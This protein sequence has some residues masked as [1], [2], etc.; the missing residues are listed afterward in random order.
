MREEAGGGEGEESQWSGIRVEY[1]VRA[2]A[3]SM[4]LKWQTLTI[5]GDMLHRRE[6]RGVG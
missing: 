3:G 5:R 6:G 2:L 1:N 4:L